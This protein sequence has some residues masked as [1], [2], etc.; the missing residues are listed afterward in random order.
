[1]NPQKSP[2][3]LYAYELLTSS[4]SDD[5]DSLK[6]YDKAAEADRYFEK[7]VDYLELNGSDFESMWD[8]YVRNRDRPD[9]GVIGGGYFDDPW[10]YEDDG[11]F[12]VEDK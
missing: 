3:Q 7:L 1:M 9:P 5:P 2:N 10:S 11:D 6:N 4:S 12:V 8:I